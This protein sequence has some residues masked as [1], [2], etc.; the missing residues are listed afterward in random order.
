[1]QN[2]YNLVYREEERE[3]LPLCQKEDVG[4]IPWGPLAAGYLARPDEEADASTRTSNWEFRRSGGGAEINARIHELAEE[5]DLSMAQVA[6]AWHL[7]NEWVT[8]PIVGV[9]SIEQL[10][11]A[12]AAVDVSLSDSDIEYLEEP[13][14][15]KS[16]MGIGPSDGPFRP[17]DTEND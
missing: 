15:P 5:R 3:M 8:T 7:H 16:V 17:V 13:Y 2:P 14:E 11:E 9:S 4:V 12:A 10:E 1:M 6:L